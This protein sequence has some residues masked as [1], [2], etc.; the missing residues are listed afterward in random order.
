M[1]KPDRS[2]QFNVTAT[3]V[4]GTIRLT[5]DIN[6]ANEIEVPLN[7]DATVT[8]ADTDGWYLYASENSS[9][10]TAAGCWGRG[11]SAAENTFSRVKADSYNIVYAVSQTNAAGVTYGP[12]ITIKPKG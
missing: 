10:G 5:G 3:V 11:A 12:V 6:A 2:S 8:I 7:E 9:N 4:D 1:P